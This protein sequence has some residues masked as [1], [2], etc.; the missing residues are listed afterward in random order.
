[1]LDSSCVTGRGR[2]LATGAGPIR[3]GGEGRALAERLSE[4]PHRPCDVD[5]LILDA[6]A[7]IAD[8]AVPWH[9]TETEEVLRNADIAV[10]R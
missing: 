1:M 8:R 3:P 10:G 6:E 5:G 7:S 2:D 9:R 4:A